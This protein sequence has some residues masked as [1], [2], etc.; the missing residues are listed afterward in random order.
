MPHLFPNARAGSRGQASAIFSAGPDCASQHKSG[1]LE[2]SG[3]VSDFKT[4]KPGKN[5]YVTISYKDTKN[6]CGK[7]DGWQSRW[8][9]WIDI[10]RLD[11]LTTITTSQS[12]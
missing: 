10:L 8:M 6:L 3:R 2:I 1:Y 9:L 7:D 4:Y 11:L 12:V 5:E